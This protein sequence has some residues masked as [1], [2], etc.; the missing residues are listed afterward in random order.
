MAKK[1]KKSETPEVATPVASEDTAND[2]GV[3]PDDLLALIELSSDGILVVEP[4][5]GEVFLANQA[6]ERLLRKKM[7]KIFADPFTEELKDGPMRGADI[8]MK[9][10]PVIWQGQ[11]ARHVVLTP[12]ASQQS[13]FHVEWR[14]EAAEE[15]AREAET[16]VEELETKLRESAGAADESTS[17][18]KLE[19]LQRQLNRYQELS[20]DLTARIGEV[21]NGS[22]L[23]TQQLDES[24]AHLAELKSEL[25]AAQEKLFLAH[26]NESAAQELRQ[27]IEQNQSLQSQLAQYQEQMLALQAQHE[28]VLAAQHEASTQSSLSHDQ[29]HELQ[30]QLSHL[31]SR[32]S[33][34]EGEHAESERRAVAAEGRAREAETLM[35]E[36]ELQAQETERHLEDLTDSVRQIEER[37]EEVRQ[38]LRLEQEHSAHLQAEVVAQSHASE[39]KTQEMEALQAQLA[40][41]R[42]EIAGSAADKV[43]LST[44]NEQM[45]A[46]QEQLYSL[47]EQI[48]N[49]SQELDQSTKRTTELEEENALLKEEKEHASVEL[50]A[51]HSNLQEQLARSLEEIEA[52]KVRLA[53]LEEGLLESHQLQINDLTTEHNA[54]IERVRAELAALGL[55][56]AAEL[57]AQFGDAQSALIQDL[58][59]RHL[60]E[61]DELQKQLEALEA[62]EAQAQ[63]RAGELEELLQ[64]SEENRSQEDSAQVAALRQQL[65]TALAAKELLL[66]THTLEVS[67]REENHH[68]ELDLLR[69]QLEEAQAQN[70]VHQESIEALKLQLDM[71]RETE[72]ARV[73]ELIERHARDLESHRAQAQGGSEQL[74]ELNAKLAQLEIQR[75][76]AETRATE[77][78]QLIEMAEEKAEKSFELLQEEKSLASDRTAEVDWLRAQWLAS[79]EELA[80]FRK[81]HSVSS[82][83]QEQLQ[84]SIAELQAALQQ[85]QNELEQTRQELEEAT[86]GLQVASSHLDEAEQ[87]IAELKAQPAPMVDREEMEQLAQDLLNAQTEL[88]SLQSQSAALES[89]RAQLLAD[90]EAHHAHEARFEE[91]KAHLQSLLAEQQAHYETLQ[92]AQASAAQN[93]AEISHLRAELARARSSGADAAREL[94]EAQAQIAH[95]Q[96]SAGPVAPPD[97]SEGEAWLKVEIDHLKQ[98]LATAQNELAAA[99]APATASGE[100]D[101]EGPQL[102]PETEALAFQ[103]PLTGMP[104]H[105]LVRKYLDFTLKNVDRYQRSCALIHLDLDLFHVINDTFS[106]ASGDQ[107][108]LQVSERLQAAIRTSDVL[109]RRGEDEFYIILSEVSGEPDHPDSAAVVAGRINQLFLTPFEVGGQKFELT[110]SLG[111]SQYPADSADVDQMFEHAAI[112]MRRCKEKGRNQIQFYTSRLQERFEARGRL[113]VELRKAIDQNQFQMLYQPIVSL[114][115]G[116]LVGVESLLRWN[117]P[118]YGTLLP[119]HFLEVAEE[120]GLLNVLGRWII[121]QA[122][123]QSLEWT[124]AGL[125][126]FVSVNLSHREFLQADL[127]QT[128]HRSVEA[129]QV[130]PQTIV[131]EVPETLQT[132]VPNRVQRV[133]A[134]LRETGVRIALDRFGSGSSKLESL[135]SD[136]LNFIKVDPRFMAQIPENGWATRAAT[137]TVQLAK[138]LE[139]QSIAV[140]LETDAQ[141]QF[142]RDVNC[143]YVQGNLIYVPVQAQIVSEL[144]RAGR[145]LR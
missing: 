122:C 20:Q 76:E 106:W 58:E 113:R 4:E 104:N 29:I 69:A 23:L 68:L 121:L 136:Y 59:E 82:V 46:L 120:S 96:S 87:T 134:S 105:N 72:E 141:L 30:G 97:E 36:A 64:T 38:S 50:V 85:R 22:T 93:D 25:E 3:N 14:I 47:E 9:V 12:L 133:L 102:D 1:R 80:E 70:T 65:E 60:A 118:S 111:V 43:A 61:L 39:V 142:C 127:V 15:R 124:Q 109:G 53:E 5:N 103:D 126:L 19:E 101:E 42:E 139:L 32:L 132:L 143:D 140:G 57:E 94:A 100:G 108:L 2:S 119:E 75:V 45:E 51:G 116:S 67:T 138:S 74:D 114:Q 71:A 98:A 131:L 117:H 44:Q 89:E 16:K 8:H 79:S 62:R 52:W 10:S 66:E 73:Q 21:E 41:L 31:E 78:E 49:L 99:Q 18:G 115:S 83:D 110:G 35:E 48:A 130:R 63:E 56:Q 91:E 145:L 54:E 129:M 55:E 6:A 40:Q 27:Q 123:K 33:Q 107:L 144:Y 37:L 13:S 24:Q 81:T 125:D 92:S 135:K 128:V 7:A 90:L 26:G 17:S 112:A 137:A 77:L 95:L 11:E 34:V 84:A 28:M 86:E 88:A